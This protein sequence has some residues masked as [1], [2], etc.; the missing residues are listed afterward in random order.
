MREQPGYI[1]HKTSDR[2]K[3]THVKFERDSLI[4]LAL[5]F[6]DQDIH[7]TLVSARNWKG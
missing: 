7:T 6:R 5:L 2:W 1:E 3:D 4:V